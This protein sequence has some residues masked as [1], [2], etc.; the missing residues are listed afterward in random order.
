MILHLCFVSFLIPI[1]LFYRVLPFFF[2][3]SMYFLV[4]LKFTY[5]K[6]SFWNECGSYFLF[7]SIDVYMGKV[8]KLW[9]NGAKRDRF[10]DHCIPCMIYL[11]TG[12]Y[13]EKYEWYMKN[14]WNRYCVI[15]YRETHMMPVYLSDFVIRSWKDLWRVYIFKLISRNADKS[16][17]LHICIQII[18]NSFS[19]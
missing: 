6:V 3:F 9:K 18:K 17:I 15:R 1:F 19:C 8:I 14:I 13:H 12:K 7:F 16:Q 10:I 5:K 2:F 4:E 11:E